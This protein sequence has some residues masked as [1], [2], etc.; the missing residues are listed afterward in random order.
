MTLLYWGKVV[1]EEY[2]NAWET[3]AFMFQICLLRNMSYNSE[4][5][6]EKWYVS[7]SFSVKEHWRAL[8]NKFTW[9][10][11]EKDIQEQSKFKGYFTK[12]SQIK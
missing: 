11:K 12:H 6:N 8:P 7:F 10:E 2:D 3:L 4:I 5:D 1:L 9:V